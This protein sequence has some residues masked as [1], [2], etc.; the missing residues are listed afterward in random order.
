MSLGRP[1]SSIATF[2]KLGNDMNDGGLIGNGGHSG[3]PAGSYETNELTT[4]ASII[5][6]ASLTMLDPRTFTHTARTATSI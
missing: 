4:N 6:T 3:Q 1:S 2:T 5:P